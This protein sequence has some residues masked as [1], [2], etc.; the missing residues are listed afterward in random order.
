[1]SLILMQNSF[2][3]S[4][5]L[6]FLLLGGGDG[7]V[8]L[9]QM[10]GELLVGRLGEH[11]LLPQVGS[12]VSVGLT[13]GGVCGLGKI[14]KSSGRA[15]SGGVAILDTI[16]AIPKSFLGTGAQTRPVPRGAGMRRTK[17][18]PHLPVTLQ[19]TV[20]GLPILL[21]QKPLRTGTMES[22]ARMMAPRMAV[23]TSLEHLTPR[24]T[25]PL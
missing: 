10:V 14:A 2:S 19:G 22:L 3:F 13:D 6:D 16:P 9:G 1:M 23:A 24:P 17:M 5:L 12:E 7:S 11:G 4:V 18:E 25:W 21:P 8:V 20:W 15:S